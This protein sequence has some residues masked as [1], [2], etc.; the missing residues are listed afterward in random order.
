MKTIANLSIFIMYL[1]LYLYITLIIIKMG[2]FVSD[3]NPIVLVQRE[4]DF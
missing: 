2:L 3:I 4:L 1:C